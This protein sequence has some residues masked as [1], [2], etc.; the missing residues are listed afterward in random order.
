MNRHVITA[1]HCVAYADNMSIEGWTRK[2]KIQDKTSFTVRL[3]EF[4]FETDEEAEAR[5]YKVYNISVHPEYMHQENPW[6]MKND[7]ALLT[8]DR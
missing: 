2:W 1:A 5:D 3:G 8:L 6:I 7:I 4:D